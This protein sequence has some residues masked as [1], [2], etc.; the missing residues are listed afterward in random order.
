MSN[1][2]LL[3]NEVVY[4]PSQTT[5][6]WFMRQA[7]RYLKEYM[8]EKSKHKSFLDMCLNSDSMKEITLQPLR[9]FDLDAAIIFSDILIVPLSMKLKL[10]FIKGSGPVFLSKDLDERLN[11]VEKSEE[12]FDVYDKVFEGIRKIKEEIDQKHK[13]KAIIGFAGS[14]FTVAC[15]V[16]QGRGDKDF[17]EVRKLYFNDKKRFLRIIEILT[18]ETIKYLKGQIDQGVEVVKL[19]DSW[20]GILAED[21]FEELVIKPNQKIVNELK[22]YKKNI[23]TN[24]FPKGSGVK[25]K[26]FLE[27][28]D[29]DIIAIDHT[30]PK[31]WV[32][33]N[34]QGKATIQG[35]LD[36]AILL[37]ENADIKGEVT[38]I[39][40]V[41]SKGKFIFNLGHG[42]LPS[43][44]V[45]KVEEVVKVVREYDRRK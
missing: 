4:G 40:D 5:P 1:N 36:N 41:F 20:S 6:I 9:R 21:E 23:I 10:D 44:M 3:I 38:K 29:T 7:G 31:E 43:S 35:N 19:F 45:E 24:T 26:R 16:I 2:K 33:D 14:P 8:E 13:S 37:A 39:L 30:M 32:R 18:R 27:M 25:Y 17:S 12:A 42:I 22:N 11:Q 28:V 15:Y 34:L